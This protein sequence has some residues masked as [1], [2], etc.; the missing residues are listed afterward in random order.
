MGKNF[1][2]HSSFRIH[3]LIFNFK[4]TRIISLK[5]DPTKVMNIFSTLR[6][7]DIP[8]NKL[9]SNSTKLY[10]KNEP[11]FPTVKLDEEANTEGCS[12]NKS[13]PNSTQ[14][15]TVVSKT[16]HTCMSN[17]SNIRLNLILA[18]IFICIIISFLILILAYILKY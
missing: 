6:L 11:D 17:I 4:A 12:N 8:S 2:A 15:T 9:E 10:L 1:D 7:L 14:I 5:E 13:S 3:N 18:W 16:K